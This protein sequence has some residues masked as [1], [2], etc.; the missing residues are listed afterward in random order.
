MLE[1]SREA[2]ALN[3]KVAGLHLGM[4]KKDFERVVATRVEWDGNT[5]RAS[6]HSKRLMTRA[7]FSKLPKDVQQAISAG[8]QQDYFDVS[9]SVIGTFAGENL[10]EFRV[11]K[12]ET[13]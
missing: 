5:G 4:T 7:E 8:K 6:F 2:A 9:V 3:L 1:T 12:V 10:I 13:L 11:W